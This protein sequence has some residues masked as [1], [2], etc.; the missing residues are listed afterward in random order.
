MNPSEI[1]EMAK[2]RC[3][4]QIDEKK[5]EGWRI[6]YT[7][8]SG[9]AGMKNGKIKYFTFDKELKC[10]DCLRKGHC[11]NEKTKICLAYRDCIPKMEHWICCPKC[12]KHEPTHT[13]VD[14]YGDFIESSIKCPRCHTNIQ[15]HNYREWIINE[16]SRLQ[17][18]PV[19]MI[20]FRGD[21]E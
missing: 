18:I 21:E 8:T 4:N 9:F 2:N 6:I 19:E 10:S 7:D 11:R 17:M 3:K 13:L 1:T 16:V 14:R 12:F 5:K 20:K 15:L